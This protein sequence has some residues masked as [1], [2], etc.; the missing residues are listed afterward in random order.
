MK[1]VKLALASLCLAAGSLL[2]ETPAPTISAQDKSPVAQATLTMYPQFMAGDFFARNWMKTFPHPLVFST[3]KPAGI[4]KE[5]AYKG[6]P[7][8][9]DAH[10]GDDTTAPGTWV[11]IDDDANKIYIDANQNGDLTDDSKVAWDKINK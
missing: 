8:Y 4:T 7:L 3:T 11:V 9:G 5:P 1:I 2:A 10:F 6:T